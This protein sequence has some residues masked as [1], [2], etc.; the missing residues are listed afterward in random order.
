MSSDELPG[1]SDWGENEAAIY[2]NET[3]LVVD[4]GH[5]AKTISISLDDDNDQYLIAKVLDDTNFWTAF[6][7]ALS[8]AVEQAKKNAS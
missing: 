6:L 1:E 8:Q 5:P 2:F 4:F 7:G 3:E